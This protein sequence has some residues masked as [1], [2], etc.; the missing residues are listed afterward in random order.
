MNNSKKDF[1]AKAFLLVGLIFVAYFVNLE[2][3]GPSIQ[4]IDVHEH[5]VL[6][7]SETVKLISI[8]DELKISKMVLLDTPSNT[9]GKND[10]FEDYDKNVEMQLRM[11]ALY[12]GRFLVLY[13]YPPWDADGPSKIE[14][15]YKQGIDGLKFYNGVM[16]DMLGPINSSE[17]YLAYQKARELN[18]SVLIH[19]EALDP[20]QFPQFEQ[21]LD[22]FPDVTF[23]CPHLCGAAQNLTLLDSMLAQHK[24]LYTDSGPWTRVGTFA[25]KDTDEFRDFFIR[26][27]DRI[28]YA[29]DIVRD[30]MSSNATVEQWLK[31]GRDLLEK[32]NFNCFLEKGWL[33]GMHLPKDVLKDI[34]QTTPKK[35][36]KNV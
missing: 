33:N 12:P 11:K 23:I 10:R 16:Y 31:C 25:V 24:N 2:A 9:L 32:I 30:D 35:V 15:Y 20:V 28:M 29:T 27:S 34:Y 8:M 21:V 14:K 6:N 36:Y 4:A 18:I 22:G 19:V 1:S 26:H 13:T 3:G 7:E 17:M 5:V